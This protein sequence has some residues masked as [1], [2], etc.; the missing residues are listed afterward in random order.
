[1]SSKNQNQIPSY[2]QD[3]T[4]IDVQKA[5]ANVKFNYPKWTDEQIAGVFSEFKIFGG[6]F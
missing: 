6:K 2:L 4:D 1:M 3:E 5:N